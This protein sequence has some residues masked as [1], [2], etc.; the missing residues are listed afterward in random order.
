MVNQD[1]N[2]KHLYVA[3]ALKTT[4]VVDTD[5]AGTLSVEGNNNVVYFS[6]VDNTKTIEN[7]DKIKVAKINVAKTIATDADD[8]KRPLRKTKVVLNASVNNGA[9]VAGQHYLLNIIFQQILGISN[10]NQ[11]IKVGDVMATS[12]MTASAFYKEMAKILFQNSSVGY[13]GLVNIYL[14]T[15]GTSPTTAGTLVQIT[16]GTN[17]ASLTGTYTGIVIEEAE[18]D[19]LKNMKADKSLVYNIFTKDILVNGDNVSW[20]SI[21]DVT[22]TNFVENG[23][24]TVDLEYFTLSNRGEVFY[25]VGY[26]F[27][28]ISEGMAVPTTKYNY[29]TISY[30]DAV[31]GIAHG[32][33]EAKELVIVCPKVGATNNVSNKLMNDIISAINTATGLSIA[34]LDATAPSI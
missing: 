19:W 4:S 22:S 31:E 17:W 28:N 6:I 9:P 11:L 2:V 15:G 34:T 30:F 27:T 14:E 10:E 18:Q 13:E 21:N 29:L 8:M 7:S 3:T 32:E 16:K 20:G 25:E 23:K 1:R 24:K 12:G 5:T 26:P 33:H